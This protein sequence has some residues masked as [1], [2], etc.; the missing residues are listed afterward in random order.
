MRI[1]DAGE[2]AEGLWCLGRAESG[3]YLLEGKKG[4]ALINGGLTCILPDV[5]R[6]IEEFGLDPGK[7]DKLIILHSHFDHIG[8]VPYFKRTFPKIEVLASKRAWEILAM[9]KAIDIA[10]KFNKMVADKLGVAGLEK[11]DIEWRD[12]VAGR[13]LVDGDIIDLGG[14]TMRIME[15]PGHTAC[16]ISAYDPDLKALF[17]SDAMGIPYKD[18]VFPSA[19]TDFTQYQVTLE[20]KFKPLPV[21]YMCADHYGYVIG[22]EAA[23]FTEMSIEEA[24]RTRAEME[25]VYRSKGDLDAAARAYNEYFFLK[26]PD[27]FISADILEG[28]FKQIMKYLAKSMQAS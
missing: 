9:P 15:T 16:S 2:V 4:S 1:R 25:D 6:Q 3:S 19:N 12:D 27:Y 8:I 13:V 11:Y 28:V 17:P 26:N 24:R 18:I 14:K 22:E 5:L 23:R 10:N 7:I 20:Q 21:Q